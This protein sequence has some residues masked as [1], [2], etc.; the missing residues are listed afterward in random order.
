MAYTVSPYS[1]ANNTQNFELIKFPT[2]KLFFPQ[3]DIMMF[4]YQVPNHG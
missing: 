4:K 2:S 3:F 1:M